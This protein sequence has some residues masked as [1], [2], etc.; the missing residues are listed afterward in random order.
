LE[1]GLLAN[2]LSTAEVDENRFA[3]LRPENILWPKIAVNDVA[4]VEFGDGL[5]EPDRQPT[6]IGRRQWA[7]LAHH[8]GER[9]AG[10][11]VADDVGQLGLQVGLKDLF[12]ERATELL[13]GFDPPGE[14]A[15]RLRITPNLGAVNAD[16]HRSVTPTPGKIEDGPSA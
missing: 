7:V 2:A 13:Q 12:D 15:E 1:I 9:P 8:L 10:D 4:V 16:Y 14:L 5:S 3:G 6:D 11:E